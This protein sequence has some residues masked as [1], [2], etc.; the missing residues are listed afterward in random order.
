MLYF[1]HVTSDRLKAITHVDGTARTQTVTPERNP[2]IAELLV[3]FRDLT[4]FS[5]L[6]NTSLN[7]NGRGFINRTSDLLAYG[8]RHGLDGYVVNDSFITPRAAGAA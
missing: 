1:N 3:A 4:G 2:R 6:C 7:N 5:V 8:E